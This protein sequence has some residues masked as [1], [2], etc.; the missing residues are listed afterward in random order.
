MAYQTAAAS[1]SSE[2]P[3]GQSN[4]REDEK[5]YR[6]DFKQAKRYAVL[7]QDPEKDW[8]KKG[9]YPSMITS[10]DNLEEALRIAK[11][12]GQIWML[13][14]WDEVSPEHPRT[15]RFFRV[16]EK[17]REIPKPKEGLPYPINM[18]LTFMTCSVEQRQ[19]ATQGWLI[20]SPDE[21]IPSEDTKQELS[22]LQKDAPE[23]FHSE[24]ETMNPKGK[25]NWIYLVSSE[26]D[27]E[28]YDTAQ[29]ALG[30]MITMAEERYQSQGFQL[31]DQMDSEEDTAHKEEENA[32][33]VHIAPKMVQN[34]PGKLNQYT[35]DPETVIAKADM[36]W[37]LERDE[38]G[39]PQLVEPFE[40]LD[41]RALRDEQEI[42]QMSSCQP[43][44]IWKGP[45]FQRVL[46][47]EAE[48][49]Q[50]EKAA[51][52]IQN[53]L[54]SAVRS[55]APQNNQNQTRTTQK[56]EQRA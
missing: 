28:V 42:W 47:A 55:K 45:A 3:S 13:D 21:V 12:K 32:V 23:L 38:Q 10:S 52:D 17:W 44:E 43:V 30:G 33:W 31:M 48:A 34:D 41:S 53:S 39:Q 5:R 7:E 40:P 4:L 25:A 15:E 49:K 19:G 6:Q 46:Q 2:S 20:V 16:V 51:F 22:R 26:D 37:N 24:T 54:H 27:L 1:S 29:D 36:E 14:H 8:G 56:G 50:Q 11:T 35:S 18:P 9:E